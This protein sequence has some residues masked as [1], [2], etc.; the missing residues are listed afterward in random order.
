MR[1]RDLDIELAALRE[2]SEDE[3]G[4]AERR[5]QLARMVREERE[6]DAGIDDPLPGRGPDDLAETMDFVVRRART[7]TRTLILLLW[8]ADDL[9]RLPGR[10]WPASRRSDELRQILE[11]ARSA[12][13]ALGH[14]CDELDAL[15]EAKAP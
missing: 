8:R 12:Q 5:G 7:A 9:M 11:D 4:R 13:R 6:R 14:V 2:L 1:D 15:L 3:V 10:N